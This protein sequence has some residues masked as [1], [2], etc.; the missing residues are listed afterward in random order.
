[1]EVGT[2]LSESLPLMKSSKRGSNRIHIRAAKTT[3]APRLAMLLDELGYPTKITDLKRRV[4]NVISDPGHALYVAE[5][6]AILGV[7]HLAIMQSLGTGTFVEIV[8]LVVSEKHRGKS[9]GSQ[10]VSRGERWAIEN[11]CRRM[12]VRTNVL[13]KEARVFYDK[14][15][16]EAKK[17]QEVFDKVL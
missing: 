11:G 9:V 13:R 1:M 15:G 2:E 14:I 6:R 5:R 8:G 10:L 7:I 17:T 3:D 4:A 12:R 16:Y